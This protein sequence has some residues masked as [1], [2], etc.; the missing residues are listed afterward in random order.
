MDSQSNLRK[1]APITVVI[2]TYN[3]PSDLKGTLASY[4]SGASVP[5]QIVVVDQSAVPFDPSDCGFDALTEILVIHASEPSLTRSRNIGAGRARNDVLLFSDDD[6][7]VDECTLQLLSAA[8]GNDEVA[9]VAALDAADNPRFGG[10]AR[11]NLIRNIFSMLL[12]MKHPWRHD[13]YVISSNMR[14][15]YPENAAKRVPTEWAMG[16]FFCVRRSCM[17]RWDVWFDE[18][19]KRYA[20]AEDLDF[21]IRYCRRARAEG[22]RTVLE[23]ALYVNHLASREWRTPSDEAVDYFVRN[24]RYLAAKLYPRRWWYQV[25]LNLYDTLFALSQYPK[26][27]VYGLSILRHV[28]REGR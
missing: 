2:P 20:Y 19:L 18:S 3:R 1:V 23:P 10:G 14:G 11:G 8:M 24:R 4:L 15:R 26:D 13:G 28:W 12:G 16:Y 5:D 22:L 25:T 9:L 17:E 27:H 6:V 21:S 7:R